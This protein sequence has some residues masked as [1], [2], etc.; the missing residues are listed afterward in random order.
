MRQIKCEIE[1]LMRRLRS[2]PKSWN[3]AENSNRQMNTV[4]CRITFSTTVIF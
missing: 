2:V 4:P 1:R 3:V